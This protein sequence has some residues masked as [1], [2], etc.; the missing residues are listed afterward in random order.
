[1][2]ICIKKKFLNNL[3]LFLLVFFSVIFYWFFFEINLR[4]YPNPD[5]RITN[6]SKYLLFYNTS[7]DIFLIKN[8]LF[9]D[10]GYYSFTFLLNS[11]GIKF[12]IFLF[13]LFFTYLFFIIKI[14]YKITKTNQSFIT[15]ILL[16]ILSIFWMN[17]L[18]GA[19]LRQGCAFLILVY[20]FFLSN[21]SRVI[22]NFIIFLIACS[23]HLSAFIFLPIFFYKF[24]KNKIFFLDILFIIILLLYSIGFINIF[25]NIIY[26]ISTMMNFNLRSLETLNHSTSGYSV[27]KLISAVIP[28]AIFRLSKLP[29]FYSEVYLIKIYLFLLISFITGMLL[30]DMAYHDRLF[31][32]GWS[33]SGVIIVLVFYNFLRVLNFESQYK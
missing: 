31:L 32:Y 30:S 22:K 33:I 5:E 1:M 21:N 18:I 15:N 14:Y 4:I 29:N 2:F 13:C 10:Q 9:N 16:I 26:E 3:F 8:K 7:S 24:F 23:F 20:C 25:T 27:Y 11:I 19:V 17:S 12:E 6:L 28:I